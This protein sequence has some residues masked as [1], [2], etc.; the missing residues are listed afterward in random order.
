M[1]FTPLTA[2][3]AA[4]ALVNF[5]QSPEEVFVPEILDSH[6]LNIL[7]LEARVETWRTSGGT[8]P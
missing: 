6:Y 1:G 7:G 4:N 3:H 8:N 2:V 5:E